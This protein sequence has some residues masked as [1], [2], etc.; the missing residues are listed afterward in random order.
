MDSYLVYIHI[1]FL[2]ELRNVVHS[3][4]YLF[5]FQFL[6]SALQVSLSLLK[7]LSQSLWQAVGGKELLRPGRF[8]GKL[9]FTSDVVTFFWAPSYLLQFLTRCHGFLM[10]CVTL[11]HF[12]GMADWNESDHYTAG[13]VLIEGYPKGILHSKF[14]AQS[15]W[16]KGCL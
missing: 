11:E 14:G 1:I 4:I 3:A 10:H 9:W 12:V 5:F 15:F 2:V 13:H 8:E 16:H 7:V 6:F